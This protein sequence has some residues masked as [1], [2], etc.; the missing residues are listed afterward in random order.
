GS[1][2]HRARR[3]STGARPAAYPRSAGQRGAAARAE[4]DGRAT[5]A[6]GRLPLGDRAAGARRR[7]ERAARKLLARRRAP[8]TKQRRDDLA[9]VVAEREEREARIAAQPLRSE[10]VGEARQVLVPALHP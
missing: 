10:L 3:G 2:A 4:R 6:L 5:C 8:P 1:V 9:A 7:H